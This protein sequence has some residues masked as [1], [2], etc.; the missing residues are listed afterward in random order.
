MTIAEN[1]L[2]Y[3]GSCL[4][5]PRFLAA[6]DGCLG[7]HFLDEQAAASKELSFL[8][9][10]R[11]QVPVKPLSCQVHF[12]EIHWKLDLVWLNLLENWQ[13]LM[14]LAQRNKLPLD[15]LPSTSLPRNAKA[16]V[17]RDDLRPPTEVTPPKGW[18]VAVFQ[19][20]L[21]LHKGR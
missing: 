15:C 6:A 5:L 7:H 17:V 18:K 2:C 16:D 11:V 12:Q 21:A 19:I 4:P 14:F 13:F 8:Y 10:V 3:N 9:Q 20:R 1:P